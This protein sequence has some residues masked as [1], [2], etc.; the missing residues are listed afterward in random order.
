MNTIIINKELCTGCKICFKSCFIDVIK[1]DA[2]SKK[3]IVK[4]PKECV[5]C[6]YCEINCPKRAV[7]VEPD[8]GSYLFPREN[9]NEM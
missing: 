3:P 6:G 1:W 5:Q 9:I 7:K 4:Y 8:Y 2:A